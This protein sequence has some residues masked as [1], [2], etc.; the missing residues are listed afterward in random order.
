MQISAIFA[1]CL[2]SAVNAGI[3]GPC[4][5]LTVIRTA[6]AGAAAGVRVSTGIL[7]GG[8]LLAAA[9]VAVLLG[10]LALPAVVLLALKWIGAAVLLVLALQL[11][12]TA[13][14]PASAGP[15]ASSS[16]D[17]LAGFFVGLSSPFNLVFYLALLPQFLP[18]GAV[19]A[20]TGAMMLAALLA[21][22]GLAQTGAILVGMGALRL[23]G[24]S[25]LQRLAAFLLAGFAASG[26]ITPLG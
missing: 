17:L 19:S 25:L 18:A 8:G 24:G 16:S 10:L 4:I 14:G 20:E 11:L 22:A 23:P 15:Q 26:M 5:I 1:L 12:R 2:A 7:A 3:P 13:P 21:G 9:S 6:R